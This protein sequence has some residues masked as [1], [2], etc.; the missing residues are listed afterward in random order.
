MG[1][2][3]ESKRTD[4]LASFR[5]ESSALLDPPTASRNGSD[6]Y[7]AG[8]GAS[9]RF[10]HKAAMTTTFAS[11]V[12]VQPPCAITAESKSRLMISGDAIADFR[13]KEPR[14]TQAD[15]RKSVG[16]PRPLRGSLGPQVRSQSDVGHDALA[17]LTDAF[18]RRRA[19]GAARTVA[20]ACAYENVNQR[21]GWLAQLG[22]SASAPAAQGGC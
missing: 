4:G 12:R 20:D 5:S 9:V 13:V 10:L 3:T 14:L 17:G 6:Q 19:R 15:P 8:N 16:I 18:S 21:R 11:M 2:G 22:I 7:R 1:S